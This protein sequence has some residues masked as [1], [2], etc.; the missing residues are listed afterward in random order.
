MTP[1]A[2][3]AKQLALSSVLPTVPFVRGFFIT[4]D[5]PRVP[6]VV[7]SG[8]QSRICNATG[9]L[10]TA[11][12]RVDF[13][14]LLAQHKCAEPCTLAR[15]RMLE[16][17]WP[18]RRA[19]HALALVAVSGLALSSAFAAPAPRD[20]QSATVTDGQTEPAQLPLPVVAP[21]APIEVATRTQ[22][23]D[24]TLKV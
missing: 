10:V 19:A 20:L 14:I 23:A 24:Q 6:R 22:G 21:A 15:Q 4:P 18:S 16:P 12:L 9:Q 3:R 7:T 5:A 1:A 8:E 17:T 2:F 11:P 13:A